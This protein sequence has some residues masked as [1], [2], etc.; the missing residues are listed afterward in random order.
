MLQMLHVDVL[1]LENHAEELGP[2]Q[3]GYRFDIPIAT[4]PPP[5]PL[6]LYVILPKDG[7][8]GNGGGDGVSYGHLRHRNLTVKEIG[9]AQADAAIRRV[10]EKVQIGLG[11]LDNR[12]S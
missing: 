11:N 2:V 10:M 6:K 1:D 5:T 4:P 9:Y 8:R 12:E 3:D 7:P